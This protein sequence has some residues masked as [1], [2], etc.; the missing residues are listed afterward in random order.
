GYIRWVQPL[1]NPLAARW[2]RLARLV[3]WPLPWLAPYRRP[4]LHVARPGA[5]GDVMMCTPALREL[6]RRNPHCHVTFYTDLPDLVAGLPFIDLVRPTAESTKDTIWPDYPHSPPPRRHIAEILGDF[7]GLEVRDVRPACVVDPQRVEL[8][9]RNW[10]ALPRPWSVVTRRAGLWT[11]TKDWPEQLW[12]Q[13]TGRLASWATVI[14]V[15]AEPS[16][17]Q[18]PPRGSYIDLT[19]QTT[20]PELIAAIAAADLQVGPITGT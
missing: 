5:L 15:G 19:G 4:Q 2:G 1:A 16:D 8:F 11:P 20:L 6:K 7:L 14:E 10:S 12:N 9:R 17:V 18:P 13:L 3:R